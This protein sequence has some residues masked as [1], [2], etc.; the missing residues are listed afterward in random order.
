MYENCRFNNIPLRFE[1]I[2]QEQNIT[3]KCDL[4]GRDDDDEENGTFSYDPNFFYISA[5]LE[6]RCN[7]RCRMDCNFRYYILDHKE[8]P[9]S[10]PVPN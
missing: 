8:Y 2:E 1:L 5:E 7:K 10:H 3:I 6:Q 9:N 4:S